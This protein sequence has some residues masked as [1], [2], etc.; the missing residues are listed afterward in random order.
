MN[1]LLVDLQDLFF[2]DVGGGGG[3]GVDWSFSELFFISPEQTRT[4]TFNSVTL[5]KQTEP[6]KYIIFFNKT[7]NI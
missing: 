5:K 6:K 3:G 7:N 4:I 1:F 2:S